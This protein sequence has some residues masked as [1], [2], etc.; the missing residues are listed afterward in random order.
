MRPM[1]TRRPHPAGRN[2]LVAAAGVLAV[3]IAAVAFGALQ[4]SPQASAVATTT[5]GGGPRLSL[6]FAVDSKAHTLGLHVNSTKREIT[7]AVDFVPADGQVRAARGGTARRIQC[8]GGDWL[9]IDHDGGWR[10]GY[11]HLSTIAV[12]DGDRV[13]RGAYL[14]RI[15]T[16]VPCGGAADGPHVHFTLWRLADA[17]NGVYDPV[18]LEGRV[19]GGWRLQAGTAA[20][21]GTAVRSRDGRQVALP[22]QLYNDGT[23]GND[24]AR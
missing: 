19:I 4:P 7:N 22:G 6:P 17:G 5:T 20:Y 23:I 12:Q 9:V 15:G 8:A 3:A 14:G 2:R 24:A 18:S 11:Y 10:T 1:D 16:T 13:E 21:F